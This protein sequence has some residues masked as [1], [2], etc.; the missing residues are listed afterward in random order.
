MKTVAAAAATLAL[1]T[2]VTARTFTVV[3]KCSYTVWP[4]VRP[5]LS[6][7]VVLFGSL[8]NQPAALY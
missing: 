6:V 4:G 5:F 3:N 8:T 7:R 1:A 2:S